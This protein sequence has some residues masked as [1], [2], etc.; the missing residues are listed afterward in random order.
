MELPQWDAF[1][2]KIRIATTP[3]EIFRLWATPGGIGEWFLASA[4]YRDENGRVRP[5][6]ETIRAG[7]T[8]TWK[9][10]CWDGNET[11]RVLECREGKGVSF[12]FSHCRLDVD[13]QAQDGQSILTLTQSD[14]AEDDHHKML[15][16][17]GCTNGWVFWLTNLKAYAEHGILL[18]ETEIPM[19]NTMDGFT[20]V[21]M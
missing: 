1:T 14:I 7:D 17:V 13:I 4:V 3:E 21:N 20:W 5:Q 6:G 11:G 9:W 19:K 10:H 2:R 15:I 18:H 16:H 12:T 8:Y